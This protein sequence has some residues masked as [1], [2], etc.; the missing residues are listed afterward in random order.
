[1]SGLNSLQRLI[2]A[3]NSRTHCWAFEGSQGYAT[4]RLGKS[5]YPQRFAL[6]HAPVSVTQLLDIHTA[7]RHFSLYRVH[8]SGRDLL[9]SYEFDVTSS[10]EYFPCE[11]HCSQPLSVVRLEVQDNYGSANVTCVYQLRVHGLPV[12]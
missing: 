10:I 4:I 11:Q 2:E 12:A 7:P 1:M 5:V 9:G 8:S 6:L 3:D